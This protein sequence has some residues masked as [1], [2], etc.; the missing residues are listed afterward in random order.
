MLDSPDQLLLFLCLV[1]LDDVTCNK[2]AG[3]R[4]EEKCLSIF[5]ELIAKSK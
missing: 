5:K 1:I 3:E 4:S 2:C